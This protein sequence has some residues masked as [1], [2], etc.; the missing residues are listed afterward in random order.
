M[1]HFGPAWG[2]F[3]ATDRYDPT[4]LWLACVSLCLRFGHVPGT[5][6]AVHADD[7]M[8]NTPA[9]VPPLKAVM[10]LTPSASSNALQQA[11]DT[12]SRE[13]MK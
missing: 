3:P 11:A 7:E 13:V 8:G 12:A 2:S 10:S 1:D 4:R 5:T 9:A 6:E